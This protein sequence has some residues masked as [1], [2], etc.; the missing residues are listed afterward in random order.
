MILQPVIMCGGSGTRLWPLSRQQY[1]KQLLRLAGSQSMLQDTVQR[2]DGIDLPAGNI[3]AAP[4]LVGNEEYRFLMAEQLREIGIAH[5][6]LILEPCGR[7]TAPALTLA[8]LTALA[9]NEDPILVV[10]PADHVVQDTDSFRAA[11]S[12]A[13]ARAIEGAFVTFGIKPTRAE[14]GYG[15]IEAGAPLGNDG[16][17][18]TRF[19][20]KPSQPVAQQYLDSGNFYWNS[21]IFVMRASA[22]VEKIQGFRPDIHSACQAAF[23]QRTQD[24]DFIR[25]AKDVFA[26][27]P[28]DSIDYAVMEHLHASVDNP[29]VVIPIEV[30]WS[31]VGAWD[32]L[33]EISPQDEHGNAMTGDVLAVA[34]ENTLVFAESRLVACVG[35]SNAIVVETPDAI[36]VAD[37]ASIQKVKDVVE[38][39]NRQHRNEQHSHRKVYR[40]WGWFDGIDAG[41]RFQV[42]HI[43]LHPGASISLQLHHHRAEH[44]IVVSGTARVTRGEEVF[45]VSENESTYIPLGTIHRLENPGMIPLEIIEVQSGTYLGEDDIV[46]LD[47]RYGR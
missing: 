41:D 10:M 13:V 22:W 11:V 45:L 5:A 38:L 28:S 7:N 9:G 1:P 2:L 32:A 4:M 14:T 12:T 16:F 43:V 34:T 17:H 42:K 8:A 19:V 33:W 3:S 15:Y 31:D 25:P 39:L 44:W 46:R 20:E 37:K 47:D 24:T 29:L 40:P 21:G 36:L 27:C 35:L 18:V 26:A 6:R 23:A 30:G